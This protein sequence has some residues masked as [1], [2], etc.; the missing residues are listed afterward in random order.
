MVKKIDLWESR[1][2]KALLAQFAEARNKTPKNKE[3]TLAYFSGTADGQ[4]IQVTKPVFERSA[5]PGASAHVQG[6]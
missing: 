6:E 2:Q 1:N 3:D 4:K 5:A